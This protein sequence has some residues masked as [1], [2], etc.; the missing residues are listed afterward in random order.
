MQYKTSF[1]LELIGTLASSGV[2]FIVI[3][4]LFGH[5]KA[6]AGWSFSEVSVLYGISSLAF[7]I[8]EMI[9]GGF[10]NF[11]PMIRTG[12]FDSILIRPLPDFLQ[13]L[14]SEFVLRRLGRAS[15]GI[16]ALIY[17]L[18]NLN[19]PISLLNVM[20]LITAVINGVLLYG[21]LFIIQATA[22]FWTVEG[23][24]VF[25]ILTYGG[26]ELLSHPLDIYNNWIKK[27][28]LFVLPLASMNYIPVSFIIG[29]QTSK[30]PPLTILMTPL[31]GL[32]FFTI[33]LRIWRFGVRH[34]QS[35]GS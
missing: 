21:F 23:L 32:V 29:K 4:V 10:D 6:M 3:I 28:F 33:S 20:L 13:V 5:I 34:Y 35:T 22:C 8:C 9:F 19:T 11:T 18:A 7:A 12:Q 24:E 26:N 16:A 30:L 27:F 14:S 1:I 2:D 15:Q 25:N 17:G 31:A